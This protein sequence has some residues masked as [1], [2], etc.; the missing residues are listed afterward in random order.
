MLYKLKDILPH[1]QLKVLYYSLVVPHISYGIEAWYGASQCASERIFV[2]QKK[3]IRNTNNLQ[4]N[5]HTHFY[6]KN[7]EILKIDDL[8]NLKI[9]VQMFN[10]FRWNSISNQ[11]S[12]HDYTTRNRHNLVIPRMK[13]ATSQLSW[14]YRG[15]HL[16]NS[17]PVE[18]RNVNS[19]NKFKILLKRYLLSKY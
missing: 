4:Y 7:N 13:K 14:M 12:V 2:L 1:E 8:Y 10:K 15:N 19:S 3:A 5:D 17:L 9:G 16:W 11:S 18:L 6:F